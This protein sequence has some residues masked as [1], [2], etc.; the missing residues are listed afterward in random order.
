MTSQPTVPQATLSGMLS[1]RGGPWFPHPA[2]VTHA[3]SSM[4]TCDWW[5]P[6]LA[7]K[8][9]WAERVKHI[10]VPAIVET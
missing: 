4:R 6:R 7:V 1:P 10:V 8:M 2:Y 5:S 3:L 9:Q